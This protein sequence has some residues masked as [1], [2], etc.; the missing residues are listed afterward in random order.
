M[1]INFFKKAA[2]CPFFDSVSYSQGL[3][4]GQIPQTNFTV[5]C[6]QCSYWRRGQCVL[7]L[8]KKR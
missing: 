7:F 3:E 5:R 1:A 8:D 2:V 4:W 6:Q